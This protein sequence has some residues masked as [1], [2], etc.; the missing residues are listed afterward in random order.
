MPSPL[1]RPAALS[2]L[3]ALSELCLRSKAHWG[4]DAAFIAACRPELTLTPDDLTQSLTLVAE[5]G[6]Q[7]AG[8]VQLSRSAAPAELLK[9]FVDP[10]FIGTG[11]G[12]QLFRRAVA[13]ARAQG[14]DAMEIEADPGARA[15]YEAMGARRI[16]WVPSGAI[17]GRRLPLMRLDL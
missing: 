4:Y 16:G 1:L 14:A 2:E 15:F 6:G 17:P 10:P 5:I 3:P 7:C 13:E 11:L 9:L 12:G 8:L